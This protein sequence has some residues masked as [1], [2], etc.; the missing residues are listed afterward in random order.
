MATLRATAPPSR[1]QGAAT[2]HS[3]GATRLEEGAEDEQG[4]EGDDLTPDDNPVDVDRGLPLHF[5]VLADDEHPEWLG[6]HA[7]AASR[8]AWLAAFLGRSGAPTGTPADLRGRQH[9]HA[10]MGDRLPEH[11]SRRGAIDDFPQSVHDSRFA[12]RLLHGDQLLSV[13]AGFSVTGR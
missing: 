4:G 6:R 9:D 8:A 11:A 13:T 2:P 1:P 3:T 10:R 7:E 5:T 12:G